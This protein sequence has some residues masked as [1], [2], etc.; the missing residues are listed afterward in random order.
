MAAKS[1]ALL[2]AFTIKPLLSRRKARNDRSNKEIGMRQYLGFAVSALALLPLSV[3]AAAKPKLPDELVLSNN[4]IVT[5]EIEGTPVRLE[6]RPE[7]AEAPMLNPDIAEALK[8]KPGMLGFGV[9]V[10]PERVS[11]ASAVLKVD[12]GEGRKNQRIFWANKASS[13][14]ADGTISPASLPYK[15]VKFMLDAEKPGETA[16]EMDLDNFG[17]LGRIGVGTTVKAAEKKIQLQFSLQRDETL[18]SAP[19]GNWLA[20][21]FDGKF[22]GPAKST[23]IYFG[24]ERPTR[25]MSLSTPIEF[26]KLSLAMVDVRVSDYGDANGIA[27]RAATE[28][29]N[30]EIIVTGRRDKDIDLRIVAGRKFLS[31]CSSLLYDFDKRKVTASCTRDPANRG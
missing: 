14:I 11:G 2:W 20:E 7:A 28:A 8:L 30:D 19:T 29:D 15:R 23:L 10:G 27:E 24:I 16:Y 13:T 25:E 26:N 31:G 6:V 1:P 5:V 17:F 21:T 4:R 22:T 18:V 3:P 12:Y 9:A